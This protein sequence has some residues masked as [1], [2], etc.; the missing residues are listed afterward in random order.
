MSDKLYDIIIL[1]AGPAGVATAYEAELLGLKN[2]LI[3]EKTDTNCNTIRNFYENGK[4]IDRDWGGF[5]VDLLGN[6][7][8]KFVKEHKI[9][10][11][12]EILNKST[13][14]EIKYNSE[15]YLVEK[16]DDIFEVESKTGSYNSKNV[17]ISIGRM[18]KPKKPDYK[19]PRKLG[20]IINFDLSKVSGKEKILV[21]GG[22][23]SASEYATSLSKNNE[24]TIAYRRKKFTRPNPINQK[25][26]EEKF[27]SGDLKYKLGLDIKEII[28]ENGLI[29]IIYSDDSTGIY[30]RMIFAL[31][32]TTP[33]DFISNCGIDI[34]AKLQPI[35]DNNNETNVKNLFVVGDIVFQNGGSISMAFNQGYS[36]AKYITNT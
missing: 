29:K 31:G 19:L 35:F 24:V 23:D 2:I 3:L 6:I 28:D 11:F 5:E 1:G 16:K 12:D 30:E 10:L 17:V 22:G 27:E 9:E 15:V 21:V 20:K 18:A 34:D 7:D 26:L 14:I 33:I 8:F 32:G 36:V 13:N 25:K 4:P